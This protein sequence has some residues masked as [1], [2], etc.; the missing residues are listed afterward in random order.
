MFEMRDE[1]SG[2]VKFVGSESECLKFSM[3]NPSC[4]Y[5][6]VDLEEERKKKEKK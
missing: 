1:D 5:I 6:M 4:K 3:E 2:R